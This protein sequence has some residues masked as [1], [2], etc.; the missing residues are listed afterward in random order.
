MSGGGKKSTAKTNT[1]AATTQPM[2]TVQPG[3]PG[4]IDA[5]SQ[6]LAAGFGQQPADIMTQLMQYYQPMSLP[7]YAPVTPTTPTP[8]TPTPATPRPQT[9]RDQW[10]PPTSSSG[11]GLFG[12]GSTRSG[13][14]N[15]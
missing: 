9:T 8:T 4:Q 10:T 11:L 14:S 3:M 6:Q 1:P 5:L 15:R 7:N 2:Q 13:G 12:N